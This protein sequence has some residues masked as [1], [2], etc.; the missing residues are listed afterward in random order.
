MHLLHPDLR[1]INLIIIPLTNSIYL[2]IHIVFESNELL[3]K[4]FDNFVGLTFFDAE[5]FF[6]AFGEVA[7]YLTI[8]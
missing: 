4:V 3:T 6:E 2:Y 8:N 5:F 7:W 1:L